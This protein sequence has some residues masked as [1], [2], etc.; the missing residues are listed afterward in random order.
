MKHLVFYSLVMDG[1]YSDPAKLLCILQCLG[2]AYTVL[3]S[4]P[5]L[6]L[7]VIWLFLLVVL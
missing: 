1:N 3:S 6:V 7:A 2:T 4:F 5:R